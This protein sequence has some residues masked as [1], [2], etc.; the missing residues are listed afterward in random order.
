[1]VYIIRTAINSY[2]KGL[3]IENAREKHLEYT[4]KNAKGFGHMEAFLFKGLELNSL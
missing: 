4:E 2:L 3:E 1:M